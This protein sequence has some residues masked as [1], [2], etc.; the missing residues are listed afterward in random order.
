MN[1]YQLQCLRIT[2]PLILKQSARRI[3]F[4]FNREACI[5]GDGPKDSEGTVMHDRYKLLMDVLHKNVSKSQDHVPA[6]RFQVGD[7]VLLFRPPGTYEPKKFSLPW[8]G[9]YIIKEKRGPVNFVL[10]VAGKSVLVN[11]NQLK[12]YVVG[13]LGRHNGLVFKPRVKLKR[14]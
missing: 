7:P 5:N 11:A 9:P 3:F 8:R 1:N 4:F 14:E 2:C 12:P 10:D 6:N 13:A